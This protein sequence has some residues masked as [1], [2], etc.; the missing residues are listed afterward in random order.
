MENIKTKIENIEFICSLLN[1][2][3]YMDYI[4][5]V[6]DNINI[7]DTYLDNI[8]ATLNL[9]KIDESNVTK[10][11]NQQKIDNKIKADMLPYYLSSYNLHTNQ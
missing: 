7:I 8:I 10:F 6:A 3:D 9:Y 11:M 4:E 5:S 1:S 2:D